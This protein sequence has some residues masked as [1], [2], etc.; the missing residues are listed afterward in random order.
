MN[1]NII[2]S[3][4]VIGSIISFA[5]CDYDHSR[6]KDSAQITT[7]KDSGS[8]IADIPQVLQDFISKKY[9]DATLRKYEKELNGSEVDIV[10]NGKQKE[11]YFDSKNQWLSTEW[12]IRSEEVPPAIINTLIYSTYNDYDIKE[13]DAI[14]KPAGMFYAFD[15]K[16]FN[17]EVSLLFNAKGQLIK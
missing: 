8:K 5:A 3:A 13:V 6:N 16:Q 14:E 9:P 7:A 1:T 17:N 2:L 4:L 12:S 11:V 10:D 15:L